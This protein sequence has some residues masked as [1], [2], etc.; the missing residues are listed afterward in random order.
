MRFAFKGRQGAYYRPFLS[1]LLR[2]SASSVTER[3]FAREKLSWMA[4][5]A[6]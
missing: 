5:V 3:F 2:H 1:I 4:S 6:R